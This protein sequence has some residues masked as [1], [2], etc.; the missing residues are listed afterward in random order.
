MV[1]YQSSLPTGGGMVR[2]LVDRFA[3]RRSRGL[4]GVHFDQSYGRIR[5]FDG[6]KKLFGHGTFSVNISTIGKKTYV[7]ILNAAPICGRFDV[8]R[9][10]G[11]QMAI[12]TMFR[13]VDAGR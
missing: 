5:L 8:T 6:D 3:D 7:V 1:D 2:I 9:T 11:P 10:I 12:C 4:K 13:A